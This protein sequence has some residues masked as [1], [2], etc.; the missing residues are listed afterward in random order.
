MHYVSTYHSDIKKIE[1][2]Q[3]KEMV[4]FSTFKSHSAFNFMHLS[5]ARRE[6]RT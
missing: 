2:Y 5:Q 1:H 4:F 3:L 6:L